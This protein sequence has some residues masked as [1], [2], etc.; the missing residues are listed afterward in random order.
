MAV[1][2]RGKGPKLCFMRRKVT[3]EKLHQFMRELG[4]AAHGP[5]KVYFTGGATALLL[6][7]RE[8]TIDI[9]LRLDPEP[10]GVFEAIAKLKD[11][12][13]VN[14]E[15]ACPADF[16]P[17]APDWRE[18]CPPIA[19]YGLVEFHHYDFASQVLAKLERGHEQDLNDARLYL[20]RGFV[21]PANLRDTFQKIEPL[22]VRYPAID[23]QRFRGKVESFLKRYGAD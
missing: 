4:A 1:A 13:D 3:P 14:V 17:V 16:I 23:P 10:A 21:S 22:L 6:G 8:Q 2:S 9:D 5:G 15:L 19:A 20:E 18:R 7:F 12:L 11:R